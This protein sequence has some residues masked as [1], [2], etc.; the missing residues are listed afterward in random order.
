MKYLITAICF[1]N[2]FLIKA[3]VEIILHEPSFDYVF[4]G[5]N[6]QATLTADFSLIGEVDLPPGTINIQISCPYNSYTSSINNPPSGSD[7]HRFNWTL[8]ENNYWNG[9]NKIQIAT[10]KK[11]NIELQVTGIAV[12]D[13]LET[14]DIHIRPIRN[15]ELFASNDIT[16]DYG[17]ASIIISLGDFPLNVV[18]FFPENE[19]IAVNI[20]EDIFITFDQN[21][22]MTSGEIEIR[23]WDTHYLFQSFSW[24]SPNISVSDQTLIIDPSD[25]DFDSRYYVLISLNAI[26]STN[27][28][29]FFGGIHN[30]ITWSFTTGDFCSNNNPANNLLCNDN[31]TLNE[32]VD[33][34]NQSITEEAGF[35]ISSSVISGNGSLVYNSYNNIIL[36]H[37]FEVETNSQFTAQIINC[38]ELEPS[39]N[40]QVFLEGALIVPGVEQY[41]NE[42]RT[43]IYDYGLLPGMTPTT[44]F[45]TVTPPG[46]PYK[47]EPWNV[48][49]C[50]GSDFTDADYPNRS[51]DW[52]LIELR[53]NYSSNST[54][55]RKL[56]ILLSDG[57]VHYPDGGLCDVYPGLE[58]HIVIKHRNHLPI[59]SPLLFIDENLQFTFDF[60]IQDSQQVSPFDIGQL[61]LTNGLYAMAGANGDQ[62]EIPTSQA[63][64]NSIDKSVWFYNNSANDMYNIG[65][66]DLN[67]DVNSNDK[68]M[69]LKNNLTSGTIID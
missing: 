38:D 23:E 24:N 49:S 6:T 31:L 20:D 67:G 57:T 34:N 60:R 12:S 51:V 52:I 53:T 61:L 64:I 37:G 13:D 21:I 47:F 35:I 69:W 32:N 3:Q 62:A 14:T 36:D 9:V 40:A 59:I 30:P 10:N 8:D 56:A 42:M 19:E 7:A 11:F 18:S 48:E 29:K 26:H 4:V 63:D 39:I 22:E 44:G 16:D 33:L 58:A 50:V 2:A 41:N 25:F 66:Y 68:T 55:C 5:V 54:L 27:N 65:D 28:T 1:L 17:Q 43:D 46:H 45:A 15:L